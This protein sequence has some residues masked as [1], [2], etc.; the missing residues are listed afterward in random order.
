MEKKPIL[1]IEC[2]TAKT[3]TN[4]LWDIWNQRSEKIKDTE[5]TLI[6]FSIAALRTNFFVKELNVMFDAGLSSNYAPTALFITHL[7]SDHFINCS[8]HFNPDDK[9]DMKIYVPKG[10]KTRI[11][12]FIEASHPYNGDM[13]N[14][15]MHGAYSVVEVLKDETSTIEIKGKQYILEI[16]GC[17]HTVHC[18]GYGLTEI[19]KK[20]KKEYLGLK[21]QEIKELKES[22]VE[23]NEYIHKSFFLY[24]GDTAKNVLLD[25][26]ITKYT[27]I[28]IECTFIADEDEDRA[29]LVKHMHWKHMNDFVQAHPNT[30][31][32]LYHFS[33]KYKR[34]YIKEFF[35][36]IN[37]P[38][39]IPWISN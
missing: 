31:F 3:S 5:F 10:N 37:L 2:G 17:D 6:G 20:L 21:G 27:T 19:K 29:E 16:I 15:G 36:N 35:D 23:I 4:Y 14:P 8:W 1:C 34:E 39:V 24:L 12:N 9:K 11:Q 33:G 28:M 13:S 26:K 25:E 18:V 7:H 30:T 32:I 38:N 22:G